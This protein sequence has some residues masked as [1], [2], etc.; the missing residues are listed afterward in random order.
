MALSPG[1][2]LGSY[3]ILST[4]GAGSMGEVYRAR[5]T[6]LG[7][8]VAVKILP[9]A[10]ASNPDRIARFAREAKALA[11]LNHPHIAALY[12]MEEVGARHFL[13][14]ELVDGET[15]AARLER[16]PLPLAQALTTAMQIVEALAAAHRAGIVHRDLKPANVMMT[17]AGAKLIDFGLAKA[18][19]PSV[20]GHGRLTAPYDL[21]RLDGA[22]YR[23]RN[24]SVHGARAD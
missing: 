12:G 24:V 13:V 1:T 22:G 8:I 16:G 19:E 15:L 2:R 10:V 23:S 7:R 20:A 21:A 9:D 3:E 5:D 18:T 11:A 6:K 14:M 17:K 4:L